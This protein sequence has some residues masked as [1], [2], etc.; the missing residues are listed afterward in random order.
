[1][2]NTENKGF[3]LIEL[4][5]VIAIIGILAV[6]FLPSLLNAP[7]KGRDAQRIAT[8]QKINNFLVSEDLAGVALPATG[9]IV[10]PAAVDATIGGIIKDK[11]AN[12]GGVFPEDPQIT[13]VSEG[14]ACIT[15]GK[16]GYI[17]YAAGEKYSAAVYVG[18]EVDANANIDCS[19]LQDEVGDGDTVAFGALA[20]ANPSPCYAVLIQ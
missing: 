1:M 2:K 7:A 20:A 8:I 18:V 5:I 11:I 17:K 19:N 13:N 16:Y 10:E 6:A 14:A 3:T 12:F 15:A 9:C 4:L